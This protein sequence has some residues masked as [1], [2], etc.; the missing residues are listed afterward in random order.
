MAVLINISG[1]PSLK[2][3]TVRVDKTQT[4][5]PFLFRKQISSAGQP[6]RDLRRVNQ[7]FAV[8]PVEVEIPCAVR[9]HLISGLKAKNA[10]TRLVAVDNATF[11][12]R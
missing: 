3:A 9:E 4:G 5:N 1:C 10:R 12:V 2:S 11:H 6:P 7:N 8:S